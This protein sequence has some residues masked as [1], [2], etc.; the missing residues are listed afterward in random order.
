ML[1]EIKIDE[2]RTLRRFEDL[3]FRNLSFQEDTRIY[4]RSETT[5]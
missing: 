2:V 1:L 3:A 5:N 4:V